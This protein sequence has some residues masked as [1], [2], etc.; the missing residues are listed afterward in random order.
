MMAC[1]ECK[2][3]RPR[4]KLKCFFCVYGT[5]ISN[6]TNQTNSMAMTLSSAVIVKSLAAKYGFREEEA[7]AHLA[8][9]F[10]VVT[11]DVTARSETGSLTS[12]GDF[13][14]RLA[15]VEAKEAAKAP[16]APKLS[17]E[18]AAAAKEAK[19]AAKA[20]KEAK[21][22]RPMTGKRLWEK[23]ERT[24]VTNALKA[25]LKEG[26]KFGIGE[27]NR[28]LTARWKDLDESERAEWEAKAA[29]KGANSDSSDATLNSIA[30]ESD[31][32]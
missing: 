20:A 15:P 9:D 1:V 8:R 13:L 6:Q 26:E 31:S 32:D 24:L 19:A 22:K 23:G 3:I 10:L 29:D 27:V 2:G 28:V 16:K 11:G 5:Q 7:L 12:R 25:D 18:D 14:E 17:K 21:P 4:K 30:E